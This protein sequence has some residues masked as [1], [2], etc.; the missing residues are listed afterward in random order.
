MTAEMAA[1]V[2]TRVEDMA[3]VREAAGRAEVEAA[4]AG[5]TADTTGGSRVW[6]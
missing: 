6:Q 4:A 5:T 1:L 2:T 3:G